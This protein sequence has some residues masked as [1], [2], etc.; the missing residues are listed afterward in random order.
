MSLS[1]KTIDGF[2]VAFRRLFDV[3]GFLTPLTSLVGYMSWWL[4][5]ASVENGV[6]IVSR[7][8]SHYW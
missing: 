7:R 8:T 6:V 2:L 1:V 4:Y 5:P 3:H